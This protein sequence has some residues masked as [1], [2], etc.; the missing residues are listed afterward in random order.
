MCLLNEIRDSC[1][2]TLQRTSSI[3][4]IGYLLNYGMIE[5]KQIDF[6]RN[7]LST[8]SRCCTRGESEEAGFE[9]QDRRLQK[10]KTGISSPTNFFYMKE[11]HY[12]CHLFSSETLC[13][14]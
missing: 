1:L 12:Q 8:V 10:S 13:I 4:P 2:S 9:T 11:T 7:S 5:I 14:K 3:Q 6:K